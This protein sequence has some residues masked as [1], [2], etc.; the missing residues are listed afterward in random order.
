MTLRNQILAHE[1]IIVTPELKRKK[2]FYKAEFIFSVF[3]L[4]V[5]FSYY[6]YAEYDRN[7]S[8]EVSKAILGAI[9]T[10]EVK[11]DTIVDKKKNDIV[12]VYLDDNI[13]PPEEPEPIVEEEPVDTSLSVY[14]HNGNDYEI[15]GKIS[16]PKI[17]VEYPILAQ[18]SE[19]LLKISPCKFWGPNPNE[20]GNLCIV[21][22][23]YRNSKFFSK[24]PTLENGDTIEITDLKGKTV[25]YVIYDKYVVDPEDRSC[26][27]QLT[28]GRTEIT[29]ITCTNDSSA[30]VIVKALAT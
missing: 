30:R 3:L 5:L 26:T 7:K 17:D 6:I 24:V 27:S 9:R 1:K 29:I 22:H 28:N 18:E 20:V 23:N 16:I 21:G 2:K 11:D 15:V 13:P 4:C 14:S 12:V 25:T 10:E 19:E 8:E